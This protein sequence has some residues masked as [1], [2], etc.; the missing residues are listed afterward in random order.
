M[1]LGFKKPQLTLSLSST[2]YVDPHFGQVREN[3]QTHLPD[4]SELIDTILRALLRK[5]TLSPN[6]I[7]S[8]KLRRLE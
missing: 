6:S 8:A 3:S 2:E 4:I 5:A 1:K 7:S